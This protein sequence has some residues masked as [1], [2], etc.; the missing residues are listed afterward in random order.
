VLSLFKL[1]FPK[2]AEIMKSRAKL[3]CG[4]R[5]VYPSR[6]P[7]PND[8]SNDDIHDY[9]K[10]CPTHKLAPE[11]LAL[12]KNV[13]GNTP[14]PTWLREKGYGDF[15]GILEQIKALVEKVQPERESAYYT[16]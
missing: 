3:T 6:Y 2:G 7:D 4:C 15:P 9:I 11:M 8:P 1:G 13:L 14:S 12:L 5:I 16:E 10:Y